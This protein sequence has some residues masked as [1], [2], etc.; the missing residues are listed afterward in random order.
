MVVWGVFVVVEIQ[1]SESG[2]PGFED[3][4]DYCLGGVCCG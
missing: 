2:F 4:Q 1:L 3:F